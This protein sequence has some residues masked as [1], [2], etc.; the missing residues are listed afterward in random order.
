MEILNGL[1]QNVIYNDGIYYSSEEKE[2]SYPKEG[3]T[4]CFVLEDQSFWF[5]GRNEIIL[6]TIRKFSINGPIFDI[7]GGN[8]YVSVFLNNNGYCS[9]LV[10]PGIEGCQNAKKRGLKYIINSTLEIK[11]FNPESI[12]NMG[13]FDVLEH[14]GDQENFINQAYRLISKGGIIFLTVPAFRC[15]W[16]IEDT[17]AGHFRRYRRKEIN[18][19]FEKHGFDILYST[20]FFSFLF[21]P[22]FLIRYIPTRF[23]FYKID[24]KKSLK[25][26]KTDS[27]ISRVVKILMQ[28]ELKNIKKGK[29]L[30]MGTSILLVARKK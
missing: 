10:E 18:C 7:G 15:L 16:S 8:G 12:S 1:I 3:N 23:G 19:L 6:A 4:D 14:I 27:I 21:L 5:K 13:L 17:Y 9:I 25:H 22:V 29:I 28:I 2:V 24:P 20:Y 11:H 30:K 26:H